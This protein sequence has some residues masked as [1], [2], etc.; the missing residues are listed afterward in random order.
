[1]RDMGGIR[2]KGIDEYTDVDF[3]EINVRPEDC[4]EV[5]GKY[6]IGNSRLAMGYVMTREEYEEFR[7][8]AFQS[9][10]PW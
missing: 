9:Y 3:G 10:L 2:M 5:K 4:A 7:I 1:M 6:H 8:N